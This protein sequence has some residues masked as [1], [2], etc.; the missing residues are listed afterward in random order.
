MIFFI[1]SIH[2]PITYLK[3]NFLSNDFVQRFIQEGRFDLSE[4]VNLWMLASPRFRFAQPGVA[5]I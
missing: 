5:V 2:S 4:V 1:F 3:L